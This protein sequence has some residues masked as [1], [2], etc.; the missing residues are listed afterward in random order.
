MLKMMT[1]SQKEIQRR[2]CKE[3]YDF[4][5][6]HGIC[7]ACGREE[8]P[9]GKT[10]CLLC[11]SKDA[12]KS[13]NYNRSKRDKEAYNQY[14]REYRQKRKEN[15]LCQQCGRPT[16]NGH[17]F[18]TEHTAVRNARVMNRR[19]ERDV[20]ARSTM[21]DGYHCYFCGKDVDRIGDKCCR[22]CLE[23]L[24]I[25]SAEQRKKID[26]K[27]HRWKIDNAIVFRKRE[28]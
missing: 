25:W 19:R 26:Y 1:E 8:A 2:L 14:M 28:V 20:P 24:R 11:R 9:K 21:G 27:N 12:E 18:C 15:G 10:R 16:I 7:V 23:R 3:R 17:S 13:S 4:Y 5:K 22:E 6:Q